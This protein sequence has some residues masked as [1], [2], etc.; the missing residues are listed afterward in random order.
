MDVPPLAYQFIPL[1]V[2]CGLYAMKPFR[3]HSIAWILLVLLVVTQFALINGIAYTKFI[4][5][6]AS[7]SFRCFTGAMI[8]I[9]MAPVALMAKLIPDGRLKHNEKHE[10]P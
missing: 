9:I 2:F 10:Y 6:A 5:L 1:G 7:A 4:P 8:G 3:S